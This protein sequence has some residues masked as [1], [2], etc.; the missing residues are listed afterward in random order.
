[1]TK[2]SQYRDY[3]I[4][5]DLDDTLYNEVDYVVSGYKIIEEWFDK[6][7]K[8]KINYKHTYRD[9]INNSKN[10]IQV[11]LKKNNLE[12]KFFKPCLNIIRSHK[13]CIKL[14]IKNEKKLINLK[15]TFHN[16]ILITNGRSSSQRGKIK[17]LKISKFFN[18]VFISDEIG[19]KKPDLKLYEKIKK[20]YIDHNMLFIGDNI[21]VD[22][23]TPINKGLKTVLIKNTKKRIH[24]FDSDHPNIKQVNLIYDK[25]F[26]IKE[27]DIIK[28]FYQYN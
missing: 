16:L 23:I 7:Q 28:L 25:F 2:I 17:S 4:C 18:D 26:Q 24:K 6:T 8:I 27:E 22:L 9:I 20:K 14:N 13:P 5:I 12:D 19:I 15:N 11:F 10:H 3:C 21:D 1:M